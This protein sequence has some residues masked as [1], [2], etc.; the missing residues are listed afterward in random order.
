MMTTPKKTEATQ[1]A[2]S[3]KVV[4]VAN[5][6]RV[7]T[8][9][10]L[11]KTAQEDHVLIV[12]TQHK[13]NILLDDLK[14]RTE[15]LSKKETTIVL[16][17]N[18]MTVD[19]SIDRIEMTTEGKENHLTNRS[20]DRVEMITEGKENHLTNRSTDRVETIT[21]GKE[22]HLTSRSTDRVETITEEKE[23]HLTSRSTDRVEMIT[24]EKENHLTNRSTDRV[25]MITEEKDLLTNQTIEVAKETLAEMT[26]VVTEKMENAFTQEKRLQRL[27]LKMTA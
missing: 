23:N 13:M 9:N 15:S 22:N 16:F 20:T 5:I 1:K 11:V 21:E 6:H 2:S 19:P 27:S 17:R 26:R 4:K 8:E 3:P 12:L 10:L 18:L 24:E 25:E 7:V 14:N